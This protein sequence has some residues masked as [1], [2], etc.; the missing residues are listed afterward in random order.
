[1]SKGRE[2]TIK[3]LEAA[4]EKI[5]SKETDELI[6]IEVRHYEGADEVNLHHYGLDGAVALI[7]L[8]RIAADRLVQQAVQALS[9]QISKLDN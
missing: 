8:L 5:K 3:A 1:M 2:E 7:A 4:I 9:G 6:L